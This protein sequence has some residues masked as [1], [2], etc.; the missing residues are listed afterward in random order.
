MI[1][2]RGQNLA[3]RSV[4]DPPPLR[5]VSIQNVCTFKTSLFMPAPRAHVFQ[6]MCAWCRYTRGRFECTHGGVFEAKYGFFHVFFSVPQHTQTHTPNTPQQHRTTHNNTRRQ[7]DRQRQRKQEKARRGT[8]EGKTRHERRQ[9]ERQEKR[10]DKMK[11]NRREIR[12]WL[13]GFSF[14]SKLPDPRII[15]NFQNYHYQP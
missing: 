1:T 4:N 5:R 10:R 3:S 7:T 12:L 11:E 15:S 13:S 8:R 2:V 14:C 6:H 9:D